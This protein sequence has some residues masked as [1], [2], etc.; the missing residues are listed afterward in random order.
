MA[1]RRASRDPQYLKLKRI[2]LKR[3]FLKRF[4]TLFLKRIS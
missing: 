2:I 3:F 1:L 4:E